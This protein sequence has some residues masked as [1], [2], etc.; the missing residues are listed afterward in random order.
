[1]ARCL[2]SFGAN[3]GDPQSS[4]LAA[5]DRLQQAL[6]PGDTVSLSSLYES[7]PVGGPSGQATFV[8]AVAAIQTRLSVWQVW[9]IIKSIEQ[10]L[11]RQRIERWEARRIDMDILLYD[12]QRIWTPHLKVPHPR[13]CMRRFIL[14]PANQVAP[15]WIDPVSTW[16]IKQLSDSLQSGPGNLLLVA[17]RQLNPDKI[18]SDIGCST[19][20]RQIDALALLSGRIGNC[21]RRSVGWID[22]KT[23]FAWMQSTQDRPATKG[24]IEP[25]SQIQCLDE[26]GHAMSAKL[27]FFWM[28][29][30]PDQAWEQRYIQLAQQLGLAETHP[31]EGQRRLPR[32]GPRYLMASSD[33]QW[34][35]HELSA[36]LQAMDCTIQPIS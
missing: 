10:Q 6:E 7:P 25:K 26:K 1:M 23:L 21:D 27:L 12:E 33:T 3:L 9:E 14:Q 36:A 34:V 29:A 19:G 15:D 24:C 8:N 28:P 30:F 2:I 5:V 13:M 18:L 32:L 11:G 22:M 35:S 31:G 17:D 16:T 20:S 4:V